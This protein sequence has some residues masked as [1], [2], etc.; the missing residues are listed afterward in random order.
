M[1]TSTLLL[2]ISTCYQYYYTLKMVKNTCI[3]A[4]PYGVFYHIKLFSLLI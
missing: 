2:F 4:L 1:Y 3:L